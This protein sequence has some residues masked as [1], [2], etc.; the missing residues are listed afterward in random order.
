MSEIDI[1]TS[2]QT[3]LMWSRYGEDDDWKSFGSDPSITSLSVE[4][5]E[6][7]QADYGTRDVSNR[8]L[9]NVTGS[10]GVDCTANHFWWI[11][12]AIEQ[13]DDA[14]TDNGDGTYT[15]SGDGSEEYDYIDVAVINTRS[16]E[17]YI[18]ERCGVNVDLSMSSPYGGGDNPVE[19]SFDIDV[20]WVRKA[21]GEIALENPDNQFSDADPLYF[22]NA[23]VDLPSELEGDDHYVLTELSFSVSNNDE[24][25]TQ[26]PVVNNGTVEGGL[27]DVTR[28]PGSRELSIDRTVLRHATDEDFERMLDSDGVPTSDVEEFD[29][30]I[31]IGNSIV[32]GEITTPTDIHEAT[33]AFRD[34]FP[35]SFEWSGFD[36]RGGD[37]S[38]Q[39]SDGATGLDVDY[40]VGTD[41][42]P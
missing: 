40:K 6:D 5:D 1:Q 7:E 24:G 12:Y 25:I 16:G 19:L 41:V 23:R 18:F 4:V 38:S 14:P 39:V 2:A 3:A 11:E 33:F 15:W 37:I 42:R 21:D 35:P 36:E 22:K 29:L 32:N 9:T 8:E 34:L 10:V 31:V 13:F 26:I 17:E 28:S 27:E 30:Q 20:S